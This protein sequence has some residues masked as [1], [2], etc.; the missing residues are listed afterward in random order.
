MGS[1][2]RAWRGWIAAQQ[3]RQTEVLQQVLGVGSLTALAYVMT[4]GNPSRFTSSR[5]VAYEAIQQMTAS[6]WTDP[7]LHPAQL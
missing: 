7:T 4:I 2:W 5:T 6:D 1:S 3:Y